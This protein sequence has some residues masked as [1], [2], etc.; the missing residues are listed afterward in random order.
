MTIVEQ[1]AND[2]ELYAKNEKI[3]ELTGD[4]VH[5]H[6]TYYSSYEKFKEA[7]EKKYEEVMAEKPQ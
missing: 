5:Y 4:Y 2:M 6:Y 1:I 7:V 3:K